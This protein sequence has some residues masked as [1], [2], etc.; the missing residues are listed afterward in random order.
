MVGLVLDLV[1]GSP[2][3]AKP[4]S[5]HLLRCKWAPGTRFTVKEALGISTSL[6]SALEH[7]HERVGLGAGGWRLGLEPL[8]PQPAARPSCERACTQPRTTTTTTTTKAHSC[9][10]CCCF[11]TAPITDWDLLQSPDP[12]FHPAHLTS[13]SPRAPGP[14]QS[15]CHGDV[16]AHNL[17]YHGPSGQATLCDFGASFCYEQGEGFWEA[18]E[19]RP[20]GTG[21]ASSC[22]CRCLDA[23]SLLPACERRC[24][25][26]AVATGNGG[27]APPRTAA[28]LLGCLSWYGRGRWRID[29]VL[30]QVRAYGLLLSDLVARTHPAAASAK[31]G[32]GEAVA[33]EALGKLVSNCVRSLPLCRPTFADVGAFLRQQQAA[34]LG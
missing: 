28:V 16:Y 9:C 12:T 32:A 4:T 10:W 22:L 13:T 1:Q 8:L 23:A 29:A 17:L 3:A 34:L 20:F 19:V 14:P 18:M 30:P 7:L 6:A 5:Q 24:I 15:I 27:G 25:C 2:L 31:A 33:V 21:Q 26:W 11:G